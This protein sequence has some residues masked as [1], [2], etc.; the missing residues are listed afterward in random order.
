[1]TGR[2]V[3][4]QR[5]EGARGGSEP[6][7]L[8]E[9]PAAMSHHPRRPAPAFLLTPALALLLVACTSG[10]ASSA[11]GAG[12]SGSPSGATST[13]PAESPGASS[14]GDRIDHLTG[15]TDILLRY[16]EGGGF[17][18]PSFT[19]SMA[20]HFTLYGDGTVIFR[21][22]AL[23]FPPM[24]GSVATFNPLRTA[25]LSEE[26]IQDLLVFALGEGGLAAARPEYRN[27]MVADAST[28]TFTV[29]AGG[30]TKSVSIYALGMEVQ[31][32]AD[33]PARAAFAK[34]AQRLTDFAG[35]VIRRNP[36]DSA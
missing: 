23:E 18:M 19:A 1:M 28:A 9:R 6:D 7:R 11:P 3:V 5:T 10:G 12:A 8:A 33:G 17:V 26:Q 30:I 24:Q 22:P 15:A 16:D 36:L 34:L 2:E 13:T 29:S 32:L 14:A 35:R 25:K 20:P 27:D 31:G 21:N 4:R